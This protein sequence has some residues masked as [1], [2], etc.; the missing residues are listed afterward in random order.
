MDQQILPSGRPFYDDINFVGGIS[1]SGY[2]NIK[3]AKLLTDF[4]VRLTE[5]ALGKIEPATDHE[6]EF[7]EAM[8]NQADSSLEAVKVWR[9]YQTVIEQKRHKVST[10]GSSKPSK[11]E[12]ENASSDYDDDLD[13]D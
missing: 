9:K 5:L 10:F 3:E 4:G 2:F 1:R 12:V 13:V 7:V 11:E 6:K 8:I